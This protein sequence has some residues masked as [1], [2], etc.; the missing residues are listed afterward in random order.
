M[1]LL[2]KPPPLRARKLSGNSRRFAQV[3]TERAAG[4]LIGV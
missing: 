1:D 2:S 4:R 3:M